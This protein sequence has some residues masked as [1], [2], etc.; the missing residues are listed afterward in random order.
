MTGTSPSVTELT[1]RPDRDWDA[2]VD[3][4]GRGTLY[5][6][7]GWRTVVESAFGHRTHY[8]QAKDRTGAIV[9]VLPLIRLKSFLF[10]DYLVSVPF[11]NYGGALGLTASTEHTLMDAAGDLARDLGLS[12]VEFRDTVERD[13]AW[14]RRTDKVVLELELPADVD[15]LSKRLGTKMR[16]KIRRPLKENA[17]IRHGGSE[18]LGDFYEIFAHNMRDLGT[19]VY[20]PR[21]F[22][23]IA[24]HLGEAVSIVVIHVNQ[25][26]AAAAFL[27]GDRDRMEIPWGSSV[28]EFNRIKVNML[29]YW[30]ALKKSVE[31][32]Y[33]VFDFGRSTQDSGTYE[34]KT[35]WGAMPRQLYWHYWLRRG[36]SLPAL[37]PDNPKY[38]LA[39]ETWKRLPLWLTKALGPWIV[40]SLPW[41][42]LRRADRVVLDVAHPRGVRLLPVPVGDRHIGYASGSPAPHWQCAAVGMHR[43]RRP[44]RS[45]GNCR[46]ARELS[47][48]GLPRGSTP[49]AGRLRR[50]DRRHRRDCR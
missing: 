48:P 38:R 28:R 37:T 33:R 13:A 8:L 20:S 26:P 42:S 17:Q 30:E 45:R 12:H 18:L 21:F 41:V 46:Q 27:I 7:S 36:T 29:L 35:Q 50:L 40:R 10:G 31:D 14:I 49:H 15:A 32:G 34:F 19:P 9:G 2:F 6:K 4:H 39:I 23:T 5:H 16:T 47:H 22:S 24:D 43:G 1:A 3:A 44:P 25:R 11:V